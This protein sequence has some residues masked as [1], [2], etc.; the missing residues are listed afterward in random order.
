[1]NIRCIRNFNNM[2]IN[3]TNSNF[4]N[5]TADNGGSIYIN[6][7]SKEEQSLILLSKIEKNLNF[8]LNKTNFESNTA[9]EYGGAIYVDYKKM[10][11]NKMIDCNFKNNTANIGGAVYIP[12]NK[13]FKI[14][15]NIDCEFNDNVGKS[16]GNEYGSE[17]SYLKIND[18]LKKDN[19]TIFSGD[20]IISLDLYLFD[21][22][23][24][25][26]NDPFFVY[27]D[28]VIDT[29]LYKRDNMN[30]SGDMVSNY[31][32]KVNDDEYIITGNTCKFKGGT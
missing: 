30:S 19:Y 5:N 26:V 20:L 10:Y 15:N 14:L 24:N 31:Y 17:P 2:N 11:L 1:M 8:L 28:L 21:E 12:S 29:I 32:N 13:N 6:E 25:L 3:I 27:T 9:K 18:T 7:N 4:I 23:D 16:H 22:F